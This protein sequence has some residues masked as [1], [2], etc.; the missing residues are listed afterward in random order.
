MDL[1]KRTSALLPILAN[2]HLASNIS[3]ESYTDVFHSLQ[4]LSQGDTSVS[5]LNILEKLWA[6][7]YIYMNNDILATGIL[8]FATQELM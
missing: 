5:Q 6:S 3:T 8:F 4:N 2:S 1:F 7:W